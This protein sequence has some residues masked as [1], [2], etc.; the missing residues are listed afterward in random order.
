MKCTVGQVP[1]LPRPTHFMAGR[2]PAPRI[3]TIIL[4]AGFVL[5]SLPLMAQGPEAAKCW[6]LKKHGDAGTTACFQKLTS[7]PDAATQ[8]E[9]YWG[10]KDYQNANT[11]FQGISKIRPK[12]AKL[13][14]RWGLMFLEHWQPADAADLF[15]EALEIDKDNADA[16]LGLAKV[17]SESF[18]AKAVEYAEKA[19]KSNPKLSEAH[20]VIA[21]VSLEDNNPDEGKP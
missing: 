3:Q 20:E 4:A 6:T 9:G 14:I 18:E 15:G 21:R 10:L 5:A 8:A 16:L 7:S 1:D 12:D 19:L 11:A 17:A 13:K 2:E